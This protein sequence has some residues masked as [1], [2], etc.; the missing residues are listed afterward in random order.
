MA[1]SEDGDKERADPRSDA[2]K[3]E[4]E[5][6]RANTGQSAGRLR[7]PVRPAILLGV[8]GVVYGDLGT[9]PI[10][11]LRECFTGDN[12]VATTPANIYGIV[13]IIFWALILIA[14]LKYVILVLRADNHGEG[15]I[16][17]LLALIGPW[18]NLNRGRRRLLVLLGL[19]GAAV[20]FGDIMITPA[21]SILSAIEGV[22]VADPG[23]QIYVVPL[24]LVILVLLFALQSR[25]TERIGA[26]FGPVML[27]WFALIGALGLA[28][29]IQDPRIF[30]AMNPAYAIE[31]F[32]RNRVA[33]YLVLSAA[34][35]ALTGLEALYAD[36]GH[37]G[38]SPIRRA[39]FGFIL[40]VLVLN[41]FGQGAYLLRGHPATQPFF[42]LA[43]DWF[44]YPLVAVASA[45]T[46]IAS[47]AAIT[48]AFSLVR[49]AVQ[50]GQMP[51]IEVRQTSA[52]VRGQIYVPMANWILLAA[53]VFLVLTFR[54]SGN[55]SDVYGVAVN[56]TMAVT[57]VLAFNI[58]LERGGW[59]KVGAI[60]GL[61]GFLAIEIAFLGA[62]A[63]KVVTGAWFSLGVGAIFFLVM[64]T[65][66]RG[67]QRLHAELA[68]DTMP[69]DEFVRKIDEQAPARVPGTAV[70]VTGHI[71][72]C[73]PVL[74][75]Y[76][77]RAKTLHR[78]V[79]LL[80]V[81]V[82]GVPKIDKQDRVEIDACGDRGIWRLI[83][84]YGFMQHANIPSELKALDVPGLDIDLDDTTYYIG[85]QNLLPPMRG[86][87]GFSWRRMMRW[88]DR[89]YALMKRNSVD[90][91]VF[92]YIPSDSV[93]EIGLQVRI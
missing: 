62:N 82:E 36:L 49:Q 81:L 5:S 83:L 11:A 30:K 38:R 46:I 72:E 86:Q 91:S 6:P 78:Q 33:G 20:L 64:L 35:L 53:A 17:A 18:R 57:T 93:I 69:M 24:T 84:H 74:R 45:A 75:H 4:S 7:A 16:F 47:Q 66:R 37:F 63:T 12:A 41:Y 39:W 85:R 73:P 79:I 32:I 90:E 56:A 71:E 19:A 3:R 65:W 25:G 60:A 43:P 70:F 34:F 26:I 1:E 87:Q 51:R 14:S 50:L 21:I 23:F 29:A 68:N 48:G 52:Q 89:L 44:L 13:S 77:L 40:P 27:V 28:S 80:T 10:Y 22:S 76:L 8:L 2:E 9:S 54:S 15:G 88:R 42:N 92:F 59:S 31:F 61:V 67:S 58:A 55:L